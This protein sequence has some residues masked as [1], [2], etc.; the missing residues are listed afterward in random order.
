MWAGKTECVYV[1]SRRDGFGAQTIN[2]I[3]VVVDTE[4][5]EPTCLYLMLAQQMAH[6]RCG[7][8]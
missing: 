7:A 8:G 5:A 3:E 1:T 2:H 6:P 4:I